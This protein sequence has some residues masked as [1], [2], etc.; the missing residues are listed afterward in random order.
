M[1]NPKP[2]VQGLPLFDGHEALLI[3]DVLDDPQR[4]V[5]WAC[6]QRQHFSASSHAYP[7]LELW[8]A[9]GAEA[10]LADF[11]AQHVRSRLGARRTLQLSGRLS[12][13]TLAPQTLLPRQR[14]CHRDNPGVPPDQ[15]MV[16]AVIYLFRDP[17]LGGTSFFRPRR[18]SQQM[19]QLAQDAREL[20]ATTFEQRYPELGSGYMVDGNTWFEHVAT[21]EPAWNRAVF[22]AGGLYHSGDIR[23]PQRMVA[24]PARGRLTMNAFMQCRR[25]LAA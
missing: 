25:A 8:L 16:A 2:R 3:D 10:Q 17:A 18:P 4:W 11:F 20:D 24:D 7:G 22:Y 19:Q 9:E 5:D 21:V 13:V 14:L 1:F 15:C 6:E 23:A 12:L